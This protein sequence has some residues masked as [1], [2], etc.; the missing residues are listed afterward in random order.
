[1]QK[2]SIYEYNLHFVRTFF[3]YNN[4]NYYKSDKS[5]AYDFPALFRSL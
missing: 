3:P 4:G 1:V 5:L 2:L